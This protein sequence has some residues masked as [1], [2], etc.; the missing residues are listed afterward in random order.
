MSKIKII[1]EGYETIYREWYPHTLTTTN[2]VWRE[3]P[4]K[5]FQ[6]YLFSTM[7][8]NFYKILHKLYID[9]NFI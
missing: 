6:E 9:M 7:K 2:N 5:Y 4:K 3:V 1:Y 8:R